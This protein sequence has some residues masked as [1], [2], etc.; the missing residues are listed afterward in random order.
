MP[1]EIYGVG[2][3]TFVVSLAMIA[4]PA[5]IYLRERFRK[6][7]STNE[8]PGWWAWAQLFFWAILT[9]PLLDACTTYGTQLFEPFS[10]LRVAWNVISVADPLYTAPFLICLI[11]ASR[12][13]RGSRERTRYNWAGIIISSFYLLV[14][15]GIYNYAN[16]RMEATLEKE[17][18][19][20]TRH[21]IGPTILNSILWQGT[22]ETAEHY[23]TG[24]Y[25]LLDKEPYFKLKEVPK[26]HHLVQTAW[27]DRDVSI[28]RWFAD[29]YFSVEQVSDSLYRLNDMRYGQVE[30]P[31]K[32]RPQHI[33]F[34]TLKEID[35][36][37]KSVH[38]QQGPED[39]QAI[40]GRLVS[41]I[42]GE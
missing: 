17:N 21:V 32:E 1:L 30:V 37:L 38:V 28:L 7:E 34:F 8:N 20:A 13:Q 5:V 42:L 22:A 18:I 2:Q 4:F 19:A 16:S 26:N 27:D 33:F 35:G 14:C 25:S 39:R 10:S 41:R 6:K 9:H 36:E 23:Y 29:G 24:Q 40:M 11:M 15:V 31:G 3:I 12:R